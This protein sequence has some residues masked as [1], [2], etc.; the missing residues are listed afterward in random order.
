MLDVS[1]LDDNKAV[2]EGERKFKKACDIRINKTFKRAFIFPNFTPM[3][4][5]EEVTVADI[6]NMMRYLRKVKKQLKEVQA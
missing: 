6:N 5:G 2:N 1:T 4:Q 3:H